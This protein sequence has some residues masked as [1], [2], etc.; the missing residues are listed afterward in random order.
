MLKQI[1]WRQMKSTCGPAC[2][3]HVIVRAMKLFTNGSH[4]FEFWNIRR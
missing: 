3:F 4:Y 1:K 2:L